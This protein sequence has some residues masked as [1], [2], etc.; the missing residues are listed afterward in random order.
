[1]VGA[2]LLSSTKNESGYC[3]VSVY[4]FV[5]LF[6]IVNNALCQNQIGLIGTFEYHSHPVMNCDSVIQFLSYGT[7]V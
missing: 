5:C 3:A 7:D 2:R 1:M 4:L 6:F